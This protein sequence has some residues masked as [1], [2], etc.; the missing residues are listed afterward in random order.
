MNRIVIV[1]AG[2]FGREVLTLIR[3]INEATPT[4]WDFVG[5][6]AAE[7]PDP[8]MLRRIDATY[9]GSD[10]D[11]QLLASLHGCHCVVAIGSSSVRRDVTARMLTAGLVPATLVHPSA[12]IGEDVELGGGTVICAG[13]V[14]TTNIRLGAG[15]HVNLLCT[16]GHDCVLGDFATLAPGVLISGN[17]TLADGVYMGT[18]SST[19]QGVSIERTTT[20]GAGAVVTR[21]VGEGLTVVGAPARPI[22]R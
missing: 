16:V 22:S 7:A 2:G 4:T 17:V 14:L 11:E 19:I 21:N 5:F 13:S 20:V 9:L 15:V 10:T 1:G 6:L 12:V 3:D 8:S 18:N